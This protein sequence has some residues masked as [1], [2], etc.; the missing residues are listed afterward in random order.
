MT[1]AQ[2]AALVA[3]LFA[4]YAFHR[5]SDELTAA[6]YAE[7]IGRLDDPAVALEAVNTLIAS[8]RY[9]P[10]IADIHDAYYVALSA[11][12]ERQ[13]QGIKALTEGEPSEEERAANLKRAEE[14]LN[15]VGRRMTA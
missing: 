6:V 15:R 1:Q 14:F 5:D 9:I 10:P 12:E 13:R 3:K 8:S 4:A 2:A 7:Q 11:R